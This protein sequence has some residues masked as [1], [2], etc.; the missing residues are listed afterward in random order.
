LSCTHAGYESLWRE[1]LGEVWRE[2][3]PGFT[4]PVL[5]GDDVRGQVRAAI[6]ALVAEAYGLT[7][8]EY[9]H[10]LSTFSHK[11][12]REAPMLCLEKFDELESLGLEHFTRKCDPYWDI[13]LNKNLP[14]PA[15]DIPSD[16]AAVQE[17]GVL[18]AEAEDVSEATRAAERQASYEQVA[19][20]EARRKRRRGRR[21]RGGGR[22]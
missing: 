17:Q 9:E 2:P 4:W 3:A 20:G 22:A 10:V 11:S 16:S 12:Y 21:E 14:Q 8:R 1:Q 19:E 5:Y 7:R 6:D 18:Y 15:I 13:S